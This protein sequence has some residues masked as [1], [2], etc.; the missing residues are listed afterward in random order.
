MSCNLASNLLSEVFGSL[1][2]VSQI[3][4]LMLPPR[5][6]SYQGRPGKQP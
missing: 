5:F 3:A 6:P 4:S 1:L 2:S